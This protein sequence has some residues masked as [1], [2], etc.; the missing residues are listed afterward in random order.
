MKKIVIT[1]AL[2]VLILG[3]C[4]SKHIE[5]KAEPETRPECSIAV[6]AVFDE[7]L[8]TLGAHLSGSDEAYSSILKS[9]LISLADTA[10]V[11]AFLNEQKPLLDSLRLKSA[12]I[13]SR[14]TSAMNLMLYRDLPVLVDTLYK[15][16]LAQ[17]PGFYDDLLVSFKFHNVHDWQTVTTELRSH[18]LLF[19]LNGEIV[20]ATLVN[21]P[22]EDGQ[23][24][25][26]LPPDMAEQFFGEI[27]PQ[28]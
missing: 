22:I 27:I 14:D 6:Y 26:V 20:D 10:G 25:F 24:S 12:W 23:C 15:A 11:N 18:H 5:A 7:D 1:L 17:M 8:D 21:Y 9:R 4:V 3:A 19:S 16:D 13:V 28:D 2:A